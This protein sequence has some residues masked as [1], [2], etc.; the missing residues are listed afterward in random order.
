MICSEKTDGEG[1]LWPVATSWAGNG[2]LSRPYS[3]RF[4][5]VVAGTQEIKYWILGWGSHAQVL[6]PEVLKEEICAQAMATLNL[7]QNVAE[8]RETTFK[9]GEPGA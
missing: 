1:I 2:G 9:Y 7:Y 4:D 3:P 5:A 6:E 8:V